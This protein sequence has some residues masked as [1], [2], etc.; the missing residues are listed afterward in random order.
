M[1]VLFTTVSQFLAEF[2]V[3]SSIQEIEAEVKW[4][5]LD[6]AA[7]ERPVMLEQGS[8]GRWVATC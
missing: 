1:S 3:H 5:A 2:L 4:R 7:R 8:Q 6:W